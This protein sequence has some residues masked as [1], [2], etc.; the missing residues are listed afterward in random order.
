MS[1]QATN[2]AMRE[3]STH[4][5]ARA[6]L[7][8]MCLADYA[9][10]DGTGAY[11]KLA[12]ISAI[13]EIPER[14]V[15]RKLNLLKE[16]GL[17]RLGDQ[18]LTAG[19]P[20]DK[21]PKVYDLVMGTVR[22]SG[23]SETLE[24]ARHMEANEHPWDTGCQND[25]PTIYKE[26][27]GEKTTPRETER[28]DTGDTPRGDKTTP[29]IR[30]NNHYESNTPIAPKGAKRHELPKTWQPNANAIAL[31]AAIGADL[32]AERERF[33][34]HA[35]ANRRRLADWDKGFELRLRTAA[36][37]PVRAT[38]EPPKKPHT[39]SWACEHVHGILD[40]FDI[41]HDDLQTATMIANR[42]KHGDTTDM[43]VDDLTELR[44]HELWEAA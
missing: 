17:I 23:M 3:A 1:W 35:L 22:E 33:V 36:A 20:K 19:Y 29:H 9:R 28:G 18:R 25:T 43:I 15:I 5:D 26:Q 38:D 39:H 42:L 4:G 12:T 40:R 8:L 32:D 6:K 24:T 30:K 14:T 7:V 13:T 21:R 11:P 10:P 37:K 31:A 41:S 44:E 16:L 2:R 34:L 27:R